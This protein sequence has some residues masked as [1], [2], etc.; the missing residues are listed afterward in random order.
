MMTNVKKM[1]KASL[2]LAAVI[3]VTGFNAARAEEVPEPDATL[4]D[5]VSL[6]LGVDLY[7]HYVWRGMLLTDDPVVQPSVTVGF[8][9][10]ALN[11][12]GS[13][14]TTDLNERGTGGPTYRMQELDFTLSYDVTV[15]DVVNLGI[16][17]IE[18]TFPGTPFP[19]TSEV[20]ASVGLDVILEPTLAVYWDFDEV[21]GFYAN[22]SVGHT[23]ELTESLQLSLGAAL[24]WGDKNY[25]EYYF[26][27]WADPESSLA[28]YTFSASLDYAV[29]DAFSISFILAYS[30]FV[31]TDVAE[32]AEAGYY[33]DDEA[34]IYGGVS[35][36]YSF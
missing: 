11:V 25:Y 24:G 3:G 33:N 35:F 27:G 28:D 18:Y 1:V 36:S 26:G 14:D 7:S 31:E 15:A 20:Y 6:E 12:W 30:D 2:A 13:I 16:G 17:Y 22:L 5:A 29:N 32:A 9:G 34:S 23:F 10:F 4:M 19:R 21:E 8:A